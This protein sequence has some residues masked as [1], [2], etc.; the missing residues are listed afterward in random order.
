MKSHTLFHR[1]PNSTNAV[2]SY[3]HLC[4]GPTPDVLNVAMMAI[5]KLDMAATLQ[6]LAVTSGVSVTYER[7]TVDVLQLFWLCTSLTVTSLKLWYWTRHSFVLIWRHVYSSSSSHPFHTLSKR[8]SVHAHKHFLLTWTSF[9]LHICIYNIVFLFCTVLI[10][11]EGS[12][13]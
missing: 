1:L 7:V 12:L 6:H 9:T 11:K 10:I 2:E 5:Y 13:Q 4:K 3:T 8:H